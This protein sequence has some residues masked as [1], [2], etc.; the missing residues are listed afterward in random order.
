MLG[1]RV[2]RLVHGN[3]NVFEAETQGLIVKL[4]NN[5]VG[6]EWSGGMHTDTQPD[7]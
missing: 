7:T 4:Q 2:E 5:L 3:K 6:G 1:A